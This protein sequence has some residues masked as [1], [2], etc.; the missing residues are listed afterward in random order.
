MKYLKKK[1]ELVMF[2]RFLNLNKFVI[3]FSDI[4]KL[5][6][7]ENKVKSKM[8]S[9]YLMN[10]LL[11]ILNIR[12]FSSNNFLFIQC[13]DT[14]ASYKNFLLKNLDRISFFKFKNFYFRDIN[15]SL[16]NI[17]KFLN[18]FTFLTLFRSSLLKKLHL[19]FYFTNKY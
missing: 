2:R 12:G 4:E 15:Y 17:L 10:Y 5:S 11:K 14:S 7:R 19:L 8:T 6:G 9:L 1:I 13:F 18:T 3:F 16:N